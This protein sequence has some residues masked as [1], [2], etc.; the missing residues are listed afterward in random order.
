MHSAGKPPNNG[1][2]LV[3]QSSTP[4]TGVSGEPARCRWWPRGLRPPSRGP[5]VSVHVA[6]RPPAG[7]RGLR[8][9]RMAHRPLGHGRRGRGP[10]P[11][12]ETLH[13]TPDGPPAVCTQDVPPPLRASRPCPFTVREWGWRGR[14]QARHWCRGSLPSSEPAGRCP[15][16]SVEA[17]L[18]PSDRLLLLSP[19][20]AAANAW[21]FK[22]LLQVTLRT[23]IWDEL[24]KAPEAAVMAQDASGDGQPAS[25][26]GAL[27]G[28]HAPDGRSRQNPST[29]ARN[30]FIMGKCAAPYVEGSSSS[31]S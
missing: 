16:R 10:G 6:W 5:R 2:S 13:G 24:P 11:G 7:I 23:R 26:F 4:G 29:S 14:R 19:Q 3:H 15:T 17:L 20:V 27:A 18:L 22:T 28:G 21:A 30:P 12:T 1:Q 9:L 25:G 31:G 8:D